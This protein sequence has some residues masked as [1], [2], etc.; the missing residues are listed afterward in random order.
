MPVD[1]VINSHSHED[2]MAGNGLF[3][4]ARVHIHHE[5]LLGARSRSTD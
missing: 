1:A 4:D 5:D 2:H 3:A